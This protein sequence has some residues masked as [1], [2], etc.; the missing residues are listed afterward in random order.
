[1]SAQYVPVAFS[2]H[3]AHV[4]VFNTPDMLSLSQLQLVAGDDRH[5]HHGI[6]LARNA[7]YAASKAGHH[8]C[9][10]LFN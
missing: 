7:I 1:M 3:F 8:G 2:D 9:A 6:N 4:V 5:I 10:P